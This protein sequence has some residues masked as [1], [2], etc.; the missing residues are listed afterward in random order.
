[1]TGTSALQRKRPRKAVGPT[2][3]TYLRPE[4]T[5]KVMSIVLALMSEVA[6]LRERIDTHERLALQGVAPTPAALDG[7][8]ADAE[9]DAAREAWHEAYIKRLLRVVLEET[10]S[11]P[12]D[13]LPDPL[14]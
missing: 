8:E 1:M 4:D 2:R 14:G 13:P 7:F 6:S 9:T 10:E 5:D 3:P 11:R 12:C